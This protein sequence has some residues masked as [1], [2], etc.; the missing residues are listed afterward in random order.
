MRHVNF[1]RKPDTLTPIGKWCR[2]SGDVPFDN[3]IKLLK[4]IELP[5]NLMLVQDYERNFWV[6][7]MHFVSK[8]VL[9]RKCQ[10]LTVGWNTG[11]FEIC[12][13]LLTHW[14]ILHT[15]Q[16]GKQLDT[17]LN[18]V[19]ETLY[20]ERLT[21][22]VHMRIFKISGSHC[23]FTSRC[24]KIYGTLVKMRLSQRTVW[25]NQ[26]NNW[27]LFPIQPISTIFLN[28]T[29]IPNWRR[30]IIRPVWHVL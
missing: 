3:A 18:Y 14:C 12:H 8:T 10:G 22:R 25:C 26:L 13:S 17:Y 28:V 24:P 20:N 11:V 15:I 27:K 16:L 9:E 19:V 30:I 4:K 2:S 7:Q 29:L 21:V 1:A 5:I 6:N 23:C